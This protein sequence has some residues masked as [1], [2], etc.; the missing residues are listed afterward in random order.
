[1]FMNHSV[2]GTMDLANVLH[3]I[4]KNF[5]ILHGHRQNDMFRTH[6]LQWT[7]AGRVISAM[8][9]SNP[10]VLGGRFENMLD[11]QL[12]NELFI[13]ELGAKAEYLAL[14]EFVTFA[15]SISEERIKQKTDEYRDKFVLH[16]DLS[17]ALLKKTARHD[18]ALR[19]LLDKYHSYAFGIN[20]VNACSLSAVADGLHV[21]ASILMT[22]GK[23]Y[24]GEG[25]WETAMF[26]RGLQS[27]FGYDK[28][29]FTEIFSVGYKDAR[30]VLRHWGEGNFAMA[31]QKPILAPSVFNG[32]QKASFSICDF[33]FQP[34]RVTLV[35]L[36][37]TPRSEGQIISI[38][39]T[40][41]SERLPKGSGPRAIFKPNTDDI[42][43][44]LNDYSTLGG[45]HHLVMVKGDGLSLLNKLAKIT[46]WEYFKL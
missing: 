38:S 33:E 19:Q 44:L 28:V 8:K 18:L 34:G 2:H 13:R 14:E 46:G 15:Q 42:Y 35:N 4:G 22:E 41:E 7:Q 9:K 11:L 43:K 17:D 5:G 39:G 31:R 45:S 12:D 21:P 1:M 30:L 37:A 25:D 26:M 27:V 36:N 16:K 32:A 20:F 24:A 29:S 10:V 40:I 3:R 23:G 6:L